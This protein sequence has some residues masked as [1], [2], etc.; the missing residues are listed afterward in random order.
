M[1]HLLASILLLVSL[2]APAQTTVEDVVTSPTTFAVCKTV[3]VLSTAHLLSI[4]GFR[5]ANPIVAWAISGGSYLPLIA[6]SVAMYLF[7]K[8][9]DNPYA[10][11]AANL[12]TC[13]VAIHNLTLI[14]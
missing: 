2:H 10:T 6:V 4:G 8:D 12:I 11:G 5:E 9:L 3:D 14:P 1:R 13:G 7:L